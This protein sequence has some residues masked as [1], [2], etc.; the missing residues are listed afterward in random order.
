MTDIEKAFWD[1]QEEFPNDTLVMLVFADW[2]T[3]QGREAEAECM[4]LLGQ[5]G[6]VGSSSGYCWKGMRWPS[7]LPD[8]LYDRTFLVLPLEDDW[9]NP[10]GDRKRILATWKEASDDERQDWTQEIRQSA[11]TKAG[12]T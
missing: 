7:S 1:K 5:T 3:D 12:V 10:V 8:T 2:L 9:A 6:K 11:T 4:R